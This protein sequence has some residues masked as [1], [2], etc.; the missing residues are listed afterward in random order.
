MTPYLFI[1]V[2]APL[3]PVLG[4]EGLGVRGWLC[5]SRNVNQDPSPPTPLPAKP[6]RGE[7]ET[8]EPFDPPSAGRLDIFPGAAGLFRIQA[9][10]RPTTAAVNRPFRYIFRITADPGVPMRA[11]PTRPELDKEAAF[12]KHF[13]I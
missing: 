9:G 6:G 8:N 11:P 10:P 1:L 4:G 3:S 2:L 12:N 5:V 7:E 13:Y